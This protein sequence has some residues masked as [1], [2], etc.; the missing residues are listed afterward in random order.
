MEPSANIALIGHVGAVKSPTAPT[1]SPRCHDRMSIG[2]C[3]Y[4]IAQRTAMPVR[5]N[6]VSS[7]R[8]SRGKRRCRISITPSLRVIR[9]AFSACGA[10]RKT[11]TTMD[12]DTIS[13][14]PEIG[15]PQKFRPK[16][17]AV[18]SATSPKISI[19]PTT[20]LACVSASRAIRRRGARAPSSVRSV[21]FIPCP[22]P[23]A[24]WRQHLASSACKVA[25]S[26][27][28]VCPA[29]P[30]LWPIPGRRYPCLRP[31]AHASHP[32]LL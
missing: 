18:I 27:F 5:S 6:K 13:G 3:E 31:N 20:L 23:G 1:K 9:P 12:S 7:P 22:S 11:I 21:G 17:S 32:W 2:Q 4:R 16:T 24:V 19:D 30:N 29:R 28:R 26:L 8:A 25:E 15:A 14:T 10:C